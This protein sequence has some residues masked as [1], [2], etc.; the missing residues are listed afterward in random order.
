VQKA[1]Q[2][3]RWEQKNDHDSAVSIGKVTMVLS[4]LKGG[5]RPVAANATFLGC[6]LDELCYAAADAAAMFFSALR[7][8]QDKTRH[9]GMMSNQLHEALENFHSLSD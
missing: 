1:I 9:N 2:A 3:S 7:L 4:A 5:F 8:L 6:T